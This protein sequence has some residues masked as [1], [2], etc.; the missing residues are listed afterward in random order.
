MSDVRIVYEVAQR[1]TIYT[2]ERTSLLCITR[3]T[4]YFYLLNYQLFI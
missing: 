2:F 1:G 3:A 4:T